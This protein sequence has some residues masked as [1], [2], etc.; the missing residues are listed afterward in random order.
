MTSEIIDELQIS[1]LENLKH[2]FK[3]SGLFL[4]KTAVLITL[5]TLRLETF[6]KMRFTSPY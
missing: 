2:I 3:F 5:V 4:E 6:W 1:T